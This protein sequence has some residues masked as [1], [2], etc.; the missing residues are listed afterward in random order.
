[1]CKSKIVP[2]FNSLSDDEDVRGSGSIAPNILYLGTPDWGEW[3]ASSPRTDANHGHLTSLPRVL[4]RRSSCGLILYPEDEDIR[5]P[6]PSKKKEKKKK[7]N[8]FV[9]I[10]ET[11]RSHRRQ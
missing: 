7:E 10:D 1:M 8:K 9:N 2:V 3:S 11:T 6:H 4:D 5:F